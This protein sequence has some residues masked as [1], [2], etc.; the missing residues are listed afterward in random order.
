M[1]TDRERD[2]MYQFYA[3]DPRAR[4][5]RRHPPPPG[6]ADGQRPAQ[7]RAAEQP[8][9]VD[10]GHADPLLRRRDRH[11]RQH[12]PRRPQRRAHADAVVAD[13]NGG[14]SKADPAQLY[15]PP[16]MDPVYGY[17]AV[18]VEAQQREPDLAAELDAPLIAVRQAHRAFGRGELRFLYPGNRKILAYLRECEGDDEGTILCVANLSRHAQPVELDLA[19]FRGRVPVELFR[20]T[21]QADAPRW[22][23]EQEPP[24]P[25]MPYLVLQGSGISGLLGAKQRREL[26]RDVLPG[27]IAQKRWYTAKGA[28][29]ERV[30]LHDLGSCGE[31]Q[32]WL[33]TLVEVHLD[34]RPPQHYFLPLAV[35][36]DNGDEDAL[37]LLG[38]LVLCGVRR[39]NRTGLL[40]DA[41]HD[42][43]FVRSLARRVV[44]GVQGDSAE[45]RLGASR[46]R[47][48][49]E[50]LAGDAT[51][52]WLEG[53]TNTSCVVGEQLL[54][55]IY[56]RL[57]PG[58]HPEVAMGEFL[59]G[60]PF[61]ADSYG[62][63]SLTV[64]GEA[65][66]WSLGVLQQFVVCRD[67]AWHYVLDQL[68]RF[69]DVIATAP[70]QDERSMEDLEGF[71]TLLGEMNLLGRRTAEMHLALA[72]PTGDPAF[73]P[74]P[75]IDDDLQR[76]REKV[77]ADLGAT[78]ALVEA[79]VEQWQGQQ[80]KLGRRLLEHR[81]T[82]ERL[83]EGLP[84][85]A[86]GLVETRHHGDFHLGQML[87]HEHDFIFIDFEGE[88]A[89][90]LA[91]RS[92]KH[93][94]LRDLAG[95]IRSI[96]YAAL[97]ALRDFEQHRGEP[98]ERLLAWM[99]RWQSLV[100][101]ALRAGYFGTLA[102][103]APQRAQSAL[104]ELFLL[105]KALY[106]VRYEIDHR[107]EWVS[108]PLAGLLATFV[109][110]PGKTQDRP[111]EG[112]TDA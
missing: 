24:P 48:L 111:Q 86:E 19:E 43:V 20:L 7:D 102:S 97:S 106:E 76:W 14:F 74:Q 81:E 91:A 49:P 17:E 87:V 64:D 40:F 100:L 31:Q 65:E 6:A 38:G 36:W 105:E 30:V 62:S 104:L 79:R 95:L 51:V 3:A 57:Q 92:D 59:S 50:A 10:A 83:I 35:A 112:S 33:L 108:L 44:D 60:Q 98:D 90:P 82:L 96:D 67:D 1:V 41:L 80:A 73:D 26:E 101:D 85:S 78:A 25:A 16:I 54:L 9:V 84:L 45:G 107:P 69:L 23:V 34:D 15:L 2:Y 4:A 77:I 99:R 28:R 42:E 53:A 47:E 55:K 110:K 109:D 88:P 52:R 12:L 72:Q 22:H 94:P 27:Y 71:F 56:R 39:A 58:S 5:Q 32:Q 93:S 75:L 46:S 11:G 66:A 68:S 103:P 18:N 21:E 89:V 70:P 37:A 63:L 29:I 13:R 8:A 61:V